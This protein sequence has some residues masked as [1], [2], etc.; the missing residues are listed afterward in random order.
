MDNSEREKLLARYLLGQ[1][2]SEERDTLESQYLADDDQYEELVSVENDL[3]DSYVRGNLSEADREAFERSFLSAPKKQERLEFARALAGMLENDA[4]APIL[5]PA[6]ARPSGI[7]MR[8]AIAAACM[9][10][11]AALVWT[12]VSD[13]Q[14]RRQLAQ[15][16]EEEHRLRREIDDLNARLQSSIANGGQKHELTPLDPPGSS[17]IAIVLAPVTRGESL[18]N[19]VYLAP[20]VK[21]VSFLLNRPVETFSSYSAVLETTGGAQLQVRKNLEALPA[22]NGKKVA[23][24]FL[25]RSL[26]PNDYVLKLLGTSAAGKTGELDAYSFRVVKR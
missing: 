2:S 19:V 13:I 9:A 11:A 20:G 7:G 8:L 18:P 12:S 16:Q 23:V 22:T 1:V 10:L 24:E 26:R 14:L 4:P 5:S 3:I 6:L 17:T 21:S 15:Q 25:P